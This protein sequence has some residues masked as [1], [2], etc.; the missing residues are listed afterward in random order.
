MGRHFDWAATIDGVHDRAS[1]TCR[2]TEEQHS[3]GVQRAHDA[4]AAHL[5]YRLVPTTK[6]V[7]DMERSRSPTVHV[8]VPV[9]AVVSQRN[10]NVEVWRGGEEV[11]VGGGGRGGLKGVWT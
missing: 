2:G 6:D 11:G 4:S 5:K 7:A 3:T 9:T 1:R 8:F 10:C